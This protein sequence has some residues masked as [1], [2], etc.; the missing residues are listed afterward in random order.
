MA[1]VAAI[2]DRLVVISNG[3]AVAEGSPDELRRRTGEEDLEDVFL[4]LTGE[5]VDA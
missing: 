4:A 1:E 5:P 2:S 3:R